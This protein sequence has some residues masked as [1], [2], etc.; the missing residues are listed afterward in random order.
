MEDRTKYLTFTPWQGD[1]NNTRMCFETALVLAYLS[2]RCLVMPRGYR[3]HEEPEVDFGAF[4]PVHPGQFFNLDALRGIV[5]IVSE[6]DYERAAGSDGPGDRVE[7]RFDPGTAVFCFPSMPPEGSREAASL[8]AFAASRPGRLEMTPEMDASRTLHVATPML[9]HFYTF[10]HVSDPHRAVCCKRLVRD[11]VRFREPIVRTALRLADALGAFSAVHV[12]RNDFITQ[13]PEQDL[14]PDRLL[15]SLR[16]RVPTGSRLYVATDEPDRR[17][18]D[19]FQTH[20]EV[21]FADGVLQGLPDDLP[22]GSLACVEQE[23]C[24]RAELFVGTRLSTF[25]GYITRLR[26]YRGAADTGSYFTDGSIG[27][28]MDGRDAPPFSWTNWLQSGNPLWGRE[29]REAWEF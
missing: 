1:L 2:G 27:S 11:R 13:Y 28:D 18:F 10:F 24:A 22:A 12:R 26:G 7:M 25:S 6:N 23:V 21:Y 8:R 9:E 17:F 15:A 4:R 14:G 3:R 16:Q 20:Y 29:F 5:A 19:D